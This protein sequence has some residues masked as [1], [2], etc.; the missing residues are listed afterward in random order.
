M[1]DFSV[2]KTMKDTT[3]NNYRSQFDALNDSHQIYQLTAPK[4]DKD[5]KELFSMALDSKLVVLCAR[6]KYSSFTNVNGIVKHIDAL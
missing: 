1:D 6:V 2:L 3:F 5:Q 4:L